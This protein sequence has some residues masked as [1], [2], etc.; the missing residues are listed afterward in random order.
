MEQQAMQ[1]DKARHTLSVLVDNEAGFWHGSLG[2]FRGVA[3]I[4]KA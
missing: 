1:D 3:I 2:Y 4:S